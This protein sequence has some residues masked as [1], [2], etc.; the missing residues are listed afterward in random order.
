M[1]DAG[2]VLPWEKFLQYTT[3]TPVQIVADFVRATAIQKHGGGW[4]IDGDSVWLRPP[5]EL[6]LC[7]PQSI[8]HFFG[9]MQALS[10]ATCQVFDRAWWLQPFEIR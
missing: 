2:D 10:S 8:G 9:S 7:H 3:T 4:F 1:R 5:P 6:S